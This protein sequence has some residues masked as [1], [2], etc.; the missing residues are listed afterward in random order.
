MRKNVGEMA[1]RCLRHLEAYDFGEVRAMCP[2]TATVWH[3]DGKGGQA[4][5]EKLERL[6]PLAGTA[7]SLRFDGA[8]Q[9]RS[10]HEVLQRNVLRPGRP[11]GARS[12]VRAAKH[13]RFGGYLIDRMEEYS[14]G[15]GPV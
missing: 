15:V 7:A 13:F 5:G 10:A 14:C 6:R 12:E 8:R 4:V 2:E 9:F 1:T 3:N 11:D